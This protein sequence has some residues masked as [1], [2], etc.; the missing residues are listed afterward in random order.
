MND[1]HNLKH[2]MCQE[3]KSQYQ[4]NT[5][6]KQL[7]YTMKTQIYTRNYSLKSSRTRC[8]RCVICIIG[9]HLQEKES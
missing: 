3:I 2:K 5:H 4:I 6:N 9:K 1:Q 7:K 8:I